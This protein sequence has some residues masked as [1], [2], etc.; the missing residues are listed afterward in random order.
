MALSA[1]VAL[2]VF[3]ACDK[4]DDKDKNPTP[5]KSAETILLE[6]PWQ[7]ESARSYF[8]SNGQIL[9]DTTIAINGKVTFLANGVLLSEVMGFPQP[10]T[11][12]WS[13][14]NDTLYIDD[15]ANYLDLVSETQLQFSFT[16]YPNLPSK[17][18][19]SVDEYRLKR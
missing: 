19:K 10:D 3:T 4:D 1:L 15:L 17:A 16:E 2:T 8:M 11:S 18:D 13:L 7:F 6:S 5:T 14:S 9:M 12:S